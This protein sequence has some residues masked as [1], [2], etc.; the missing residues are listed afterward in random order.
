MLCLLHPKLLGVIYIVLFY[1]A[2]K[3]DF[4]WF[5]L[6]TFEIFIKH[7]LCWLGNFS[8]CNFKPIGFLMHEKPMEQKGLT[9][10]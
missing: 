3:K 10:V 2:M 5:S 7:S 8:C 4:R 1:F 9:I 6:L